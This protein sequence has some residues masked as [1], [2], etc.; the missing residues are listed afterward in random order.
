MTA[1]EHPVAPTV[2]EAE[3]RPPAAS[4]VAASLA[5]AW[6]VML[7]VKH[8]PEELGDAIGI[9][10]VFTV[11]FTYLFG[12]ALAGSTSGYLQFLLPGTLVLAVVF[13]TVYSGVN[14]NSDLST[15]TA[16]RYRSLPIPR[17]AA[18][19]GGLIGD[20]GRY[21]LAAILVAGLGLAM[22]F[23]PPGGAVGVVAGIVLAVVFAV[24]LSWP[25]VLLGLV[26]RTP[27]AV[28]SLGFAILFPITFV[29]NV[30]VDPAT[31][32][33]WLQAFTAA[34]PISHLV[35]AERELMNGDAALGQAGWALLAAALLTIVFAPLAVRRYRTAG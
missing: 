29:S 5:F 19:V 18:I 7:K 17:S 20:L 33:G 4:A 3:A 31:M 26:L 8:V 16:D 23:R 35:T 9:P 11:L 32:P 27:R 25:W 6:R 13:L 28:M 30:F 2:V 24:A 34:N 15:G 21:L 14:V 1:V 12:G 10:V 22:G